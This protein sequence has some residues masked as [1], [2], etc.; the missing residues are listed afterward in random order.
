M[1][2]LIGQLPK[3]WACLL[4]ICPFAAAAQQ[5][6]FNDTFGSST[7]NGA[8]TNSGSATVS[9]T[10]YDIASGKNATANTI[11]PGHFGFEVASTSAGYVEA[12]AL[13]APNPITLASVG[14]SIDI[15]YVFTD[16]TNIFNGKAGNN[17]SFAVGLF[18][19]G[20]VLPVSVPTTGTNLWNGG[21]S[22]GR[23]E[24]TTGGVQNWMGYR[25]LIAYNPSGSANAVVY[26]RLA[27]N[28]G[29]NLNQTLIQQGGGGF[30]GGAN[31]GQKANTIA[32]LNVGEQYTVDFNITV[33]TNG[34]LL[35]TNILYDG[36][37]TGGT[38][39]ATN[40]GTATNLLTT[41]FDSF[42]IGREATGS[43]QTTNDI[44]QVIVTATLAAQ[45]GPYFSVTGGSG[46][47]SVMVGLSGSVTT[48][49]YLLY[50]NGAYNGQSMPGTGSAISFGPQT[51]A[52]VYTVVASNLVTASMGPMFGSATVTAG[53]PVMNSE[54][55]SVTC[56][57]NAIATFSAS[58]SG[59]ELGFQWYANGVALTNGGDISGAQTTNL[60]ISPA[61]AG[62]AAAVANGY[63]LVA[64]N[65]CGL[66]V[67]SSPNA[68]LTLIAPNHIVW[69]GGNPDNS[70]DVATT[71]N[72]TNSA[73]T[74]VAFTNGDYVTFDD[75]S[76]NTG[77]DIVSNLTM[78]TV[79]NVTGS[80]S[81]TFGGLGSLVGASSILVNESASLTITNVNNYK[82]GTVVSNS[83]T[84]NLGDGTSQGK[85]PG[86]ITVY[87][88]ATLHYFLKNTS[89]YTLGNNNIAGT[90]NLVYEINSGSHTI[91]L[92]PTET[93][94][95]FEGTTEI[96]PGTRLQVTT[97]YGVPG[98]NI[99]VD[100]NGTYAGS[101]YL[102]G[103]SIT[104][105]AAIS[106]IGRGPGSPVDTPQG[107]G[108]LR[109]NATVTGP[110]TISGVDPTYNVTTIGAASGTG[111]VL[112]NITDN[113]NGYE[114][115]YYG[116]TIRVGPTTGVNTYGDTRIA[117][118]VNNGPVSVLTTVVALNTN[119]FSTNVLRMNG[120][121]L[122]RLN[123]N[124]LQF[125][126]LIDESGGG[127]YDG[128]YSN[129][130]PA[131]V[132]GST[133]A[134][135]TLTVGRDNNSQSF[136]G[137]FG[138]GGSQGLGLT[139]AGTGTLTLSGDSTNTGAVTVNGGTLALAQASGSFAS[140]LPFV[141]SG[142]FSNTTL[143]AVA[144]GATLN[145]SARADQ[146]LTLNSGQNLIGSGNI[147]GNVV[148]NPG[149]VI[150]PGDSIGT[151]TVT[152][153]ATLSG[154][155][156]M[157]L[158]RTNS[159]ATNDSLVVTG[160]FTAGGTLIVTNLGPALH[161]GDTFQ[162]F[163]AG[164]SG[165]SVNLPTTDTA[166]AVQYTW[167][168]T[169]AT[170]GKITVATVTGSTNPNPTNIVT[171][172][173]GGNLTLSWPADH[174][175]WTLQAQTNPPGHGLGTNWVDIVGSTATNQIIG[176]IVPTNG[177]V[178]FR[179]KL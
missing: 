165:F 60:V 19:S 44:N 54:P 154:T 82:G 66:A 70:W 178:F 129:I 145:V 99:I 134:P 3:R 92:D 16:T 94:S 110:I 67:T 173:S 132:N 6:V 55:A 135:A 119:A 74:F 140:G 43:V 28:Q 138:D 149:S 168:D 58:V 130:A 12:Q 7:I 38:V 51:S 72:F 47:G 114:L 20:G 163:P 53:A 69:Q 48:N 79:A 103:S 158:N 37:G 49:V 131:I 128:A 150:N 137:V 23:T 75:T 63:Y 125:N 170:D 161:A 84:L 106:I 25:G 13:F 139:K 113:G 133:N 109:L 10:S 8:S 22:N 78:T 144:G 15:Q 156:V 80:Q 64:T 160:T 147:N 90:G 153:N 4:L 14:D 111:N 91:T 166:N 71:A 100:D 27:Q 24:S 151:F 179:M 36:V 167:N 65:P 83:A 116:G 11:S 39:L 29:N 57:T 124:N 97:P 141:G 107:F 1:K 115:E 146:T 176:P 18:N 121:T 159:P 112:G 5:T 21:L 34:T 68:S 87:S 162:L 26:S 59:T 81:Y 104:N 96:R 169:T 56:A 102:N 77:V 123:G 88:G 95:A 172:V 118:Q 171:S 45:A 177:S 89:D 76:L 122:L 98:T 120:A 143:F 33:N 2:T 35:F 31:L 164:V 108:A 86:L 175:G 142:S 41:N 174:T 148:A 61:Q 136:Y 155:L 30:A 17:A 127:G 93:N 117:E 40:N 157:E 152:G 46:C 85:A 126:N 52:G 9:S 101:L 50:V 32:A 42:A 105:S 62:D 73:G